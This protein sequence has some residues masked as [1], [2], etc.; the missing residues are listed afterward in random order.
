VGGFGGGGGKDGTIAVGH[1]HVVVLS[2]MDEEID[3]EFWEA[4][5]HD[6]CFGAVVIE[7]AIKMTA[8]L[9]NDFVAH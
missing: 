3:V 2:F 7:I 5:C 8:K 1:G 9:I 4:S 6:V